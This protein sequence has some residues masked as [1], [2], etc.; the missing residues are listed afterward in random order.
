MLLVASTHW[1]A[2]WAITCKVP[3]IDG[4]DAVYDHVI[5]SQRRREWLIVI[6]SIFNLVRIKDYQVSPVT[7]PQKAA[8]T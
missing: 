2:A 1:H 8:T 4:D 7:W 6:G 3:V 5:N